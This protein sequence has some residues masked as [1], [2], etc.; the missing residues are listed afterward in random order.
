[1][2]YAYKRFLIYVQKD[3]VSRVELNQK[4]YQLFVQHKYMS[5]VAVLM[6][7][8]WSDHGQLR[9]YVYNQIYWIFFKDICEQCDNKF[10]G[11]Y[12]TVNFL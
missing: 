7:N 2:Y 11:K 1:M 9:V 3:S 4:N 5:N 6:K 10:E 8:A 12:R